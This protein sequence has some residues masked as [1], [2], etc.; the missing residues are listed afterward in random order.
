MYAAKALDALDLDHDLVVDD[1]IRPMLADH[2]PLVQDRSTDL[3]CVRKPRPSEFDTE[4][5]LIG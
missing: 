2:V 5:F 1:K 3:A 4:C